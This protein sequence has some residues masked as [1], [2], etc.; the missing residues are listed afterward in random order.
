M[1]RCLAVCVCVS[2]PAAPLLAEEESPP[3]VGETA[4]DFE[5]KT[6]DGKTIKLSEQTRQG[7]V[8]LLVLRGFPG[9][10]CPICRRQVIAFRKQAEA[11]GKAGAQ[12]V[13]VYPGEASELNLKALQF[14]GEQKL[15]EGFQMVIDPGYKFTNAW[16]LRW[17]AERE[18]SYPRRS[19]STRTAR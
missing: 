15:P 19:S 2:L 4:P 14:L 13:M 17:D 1:I 11:F 12:V 18:T 9:Y 6:V 8:V 5:L 3:A 16:H 7:K 10:Q